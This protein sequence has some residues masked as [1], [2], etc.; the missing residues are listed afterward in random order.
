MK[1]SK[2]K[3]YYFKR[4]VFWLF[5]ATIV[6]FGDEV[7]QESTSNNAILNMSTIIV[8]AIWLI[9]LYYCIKFFTKAAKFKWIN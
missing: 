2:D 8:F 3:K 6:S 7:I 9:F 1:L 4:G 5:L